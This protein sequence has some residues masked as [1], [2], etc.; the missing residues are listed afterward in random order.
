MKVRYAKKNEK[1]IAIKFWKDS[2]K[3]S[4]EQIK[5]YFDNIY[6]EKNYLVL[7]DNSKII[8]SLHENDYIF[9]FN[10]LFEQC[11]SM[12]L[13]H[14]KILSR[15]PRLSFSPECGKYYAKPSGIPLCSHKLAASIAKF[16]YTACKY[17]F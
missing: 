10:N 5:F 15:L 3:D 1:E 14:I 4:E 6:N 13:P 7:E 16:C 2:F 17:G 11:F 9:N 8:S 12:C